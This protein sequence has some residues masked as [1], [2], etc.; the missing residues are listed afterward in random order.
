MG[1]NN[2]VILLWTI[3]LLIFQIL[4]LNSVYLFGFVNPYVYVFI[5]LILPIELRPWIGLIVAFILGITLDT[6][7]DTPGMH[8]AAT[9]TMAFFRPSVLRIIAPREGYDTDARPDL[10]EM[11]FYWYF[12]YSGLLVFIHH[13]LLFY[14]EV[15]RFSHFF[16]TL[17]RV[18]LSWV[19]SMILIFLFQILVQKPQK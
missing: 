4:V 18:M 11:G 5:I 14:L 2:S 6:F 19:A 8:T 3:I 9:V 7:T 13:L 12:R 16:H 17:S 10:G 15:F 1:K